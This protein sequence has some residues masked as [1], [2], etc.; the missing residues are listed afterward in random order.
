MGVH[1]E[2]RARRRQ[3]VAAISGACLAVMSAGCSGSF[4]ST[5]PPAVA[6]SAASVRATPRTAPL[7]ATPT[8]AATAGAAT[9]PAA[10]TALP[11]AAA[12]VDARIKV[13]GNCRTPRVE[14]SEI[15]WRAPTTAPCSKASAGRAG[16]LRPRRRSGP[17]CT[18][19]AHPAVPRDITTTYAAPGS[20]L[21]SPSE[22]PAG[23]L[24]GRGFRKIPNLRDTRPIRSTAPHSP[25][26]S[27]RTD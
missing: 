4:K 19:T 3:A 12:P 11:A 17:S 8:S 26:L 7:A 20:S 10:T 16:Q 15:V 2:A 27:G 18:T 1:I 23:R 25:C 13:Y 14:P 6:V 9:A 22:V 21:P 5:A 24:C